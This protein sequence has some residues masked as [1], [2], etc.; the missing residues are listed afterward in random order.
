MIDCNRIPRTG[1]LWVLFISFAQFSLAQISRGGIPNWDVETEAIPAFRMPAIDRA[2][3]AE[4]DAVTDAFKEVPWR[5]GV[6]FEVSISPAEQGRW[7]LESNE[8]VWRMRFD[9]PDALALSF[10]FDAFVLPKGA[11]LFVWNAARTDFIGAFD[12]RNNKEW[13]SLAIGQTVGSSVVMEYH[14]PLNAAFE[15]EL[16]IAQVVHAYRSVFRPET[17]L[18]NRGPYGNSGACNINVNCPEGIPW[19]TESKSVA[20][21]LQGGFAACTGALV[22]NTAQDGTPY[23]LTANHCLGNPNNWIYLFNHEIADC[24]GNTNSAPTSDVISGGV[25]RASNAGSDFALVELSEAPPASYDVQ[26]AGWDATGDNPETV[27]GIHHPSG[28]VKKICFDEDGPNAQNAAGAAVWYINQWEDGVTEPGSSGS[29]LFDQNHRVVGQLYGGAAACNGSVNNG[30]VDYYGRFDVSWDGTSAS[31]RLWDWLDPA[32]SGVL[33]LDGWPEG[34]VSYEVD[35]G[36]QVTGLPESILC[37]V[38]T[39]TPSVLLTNMGLND[40]VSATVNYS[41]NGAAIQSIEWTGLLAQYASETIDLPALTVAAGTN[42]LEVSVENPNGATDENAYNNA[43]AGSFDSFSGPTVNY[44]MILT[45]DDWGSEVTWELRQLSQVLY[46]GGPYENDLD[47]TEIAVEWCLEAGCY[48]FEISDSYGD[49]LCCEY[50]EGGWEILDPDGNSVATGGVYED[51]DQ[52]T[53]CAEEVSDVEGVDAR[54]L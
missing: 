36:V 32:N 25:L 34:A 50:G 9:S 28:D 12:H 7:T 18:E 3:L 42:D 16:H 53:F 52:E 17:V 23:F 37:G 19:A 27:T 29:P 35:A 26:Y 31:T 44:E 22:N 14:E 41:F 13:G 45:L 38:E 20:L 10:Y 46:T 33:V 54:P 1:I 40:L 47:G 30:Q 24:T 39:V 21:I 43:S 5:F 4:E 51:Q 11:Q 6:E 15:A 48:T 2:A 49:G 8:R